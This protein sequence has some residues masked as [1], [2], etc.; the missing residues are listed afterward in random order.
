VKA[1]QTQ[2]AAKTYPKSQGTRSKKPT[3]LK[4]ATA[5][6]AGS[7][8][9]GVA[10]KV[11][12]NGTPKVTP[13]VTKIMK[14][15]RLDRDVLRWIQAEASARALPYQTMLNSMLREMMLLSNDGALHAKVKEAIRNV[16]QKRAKTA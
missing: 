9:K 13:K 3:V 15:V 4:K 12:K 7:A 11:T 8:K 2:S 10:K 6:K 14:T 5:S 1:H 16:L